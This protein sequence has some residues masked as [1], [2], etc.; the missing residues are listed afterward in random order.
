MLQG[1]WAYKSDDLPDKRNGTHSNLEHMMQSSTKNFQ[2]AAHVLASSCLGAVPYLNS[3]VYSFDT[4][5]FHS[6]DWNA[7]LNWASELG[8]VAYK[9]RPRQRHNWFF[10]IAL[11]ICMCVYVYVCM[12][13]CVCVFVSVCVCF[14]VCV[15]MCACVF[16]C[17]CVF[18]Y[19]CLCVCICVCVKLA[20]AN[21][22]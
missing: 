13:L 5:C 10:E 19:V 11:S 14:C 15:F 1:L 3:Y 4:G 21:C 16:V 9:S 22:C 18:L 7:G 12:C 8:Y 6:L 17:V 2:S 20:H